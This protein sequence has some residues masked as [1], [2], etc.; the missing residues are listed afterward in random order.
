[1]SK[2]GYPC[3]QC[4]GPTR[5]VYTDNKLVRGKT[6]T[7]FR[8]RRACLGGCPRFWTKETPEAKA[9]TVS[10]KRLLETFLRLPMEKRLVLYSL[11]RHMEPRNAKR[12]APAPAPDM[13]D[14]PP[15][16]KRP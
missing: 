14:L 7:S 12:P 3:P 6:S 13:Q 9:K 2:R 16:G 15:L 11:M 8:R 10:A 5:L 4:G 1:M